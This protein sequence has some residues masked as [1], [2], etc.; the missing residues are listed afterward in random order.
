MPVCVFD[1]NCKAF[2]KKFTYSKIIM[3][4]ISHQEG[5]F[6]DF[7]VLSRESMASYVYHQDNLWRVTYIIKIIFGEV[8][9]SSRESLVRYVYH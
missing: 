4:T 2:S 3:V 7:L 5:M 8:R 1:A 6:G 9:V